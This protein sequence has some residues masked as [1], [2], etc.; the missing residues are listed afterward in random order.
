MGSSF[1]A[2]QQMGMLD[3]S[4]R[5]GF[6]IGQTFI[7]Y[8]QVESMLLEYPMVLE[9]GVIALSDLHQKQIL[10]IFLALEENGMNEQERYDF[11]SQVTDFIRS[12][13]AL[14]CPLQIQIREKLPMTRSGKILR[15]VLK[16]WPMQLVPNDADL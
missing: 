6:L 11:C 8:F 4:Q 5:E 14:G 13:L 10:H 16:D 1:A 2:L 12:Q 15:T 3:G 7:S 9:A